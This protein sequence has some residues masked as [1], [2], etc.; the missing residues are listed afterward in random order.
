M[1]KKM[2]AILRQAQEGVRAEVK[3]K[4]AVNW[5]RAKAVEEKIKTAVHAGMAHE[6]LDHQLEL[7]RQRSW[8]LQDR[9]EKIDG[10]LVEVGAEVGHGR[11]RARWRPTAAEPF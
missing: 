1:T 6:A 2:Q 3:A 8:K 4:L 11:S 5:E 9:A 7:L 10:Q